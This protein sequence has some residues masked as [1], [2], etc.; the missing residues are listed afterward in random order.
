MIPH[1]GLT[2]RKLYRMIKDR[3]ITLGGNYKL[4]IYGLL[5]CVSGKTM[6][7]EN[8]VFFQTEV[9][10][11]AGGFRPCGHCMGESYRNWKRRLR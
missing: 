11:V 8:R 10:A 9:E 7:T 3:S 4:K 5:S 2:K 1:A 6:M